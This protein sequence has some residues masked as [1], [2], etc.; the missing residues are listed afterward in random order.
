MDSYTKTPIW[1]EISA[2][3]RSGKQI[4]HGG[5]EGPLG[6]EGITTYIGENFPVSLTETEVVV[7]VGAR[8]LNINHVTCK[9]GSWGQKILY[10]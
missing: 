4:V 6:K 8:F 10:R 2:T 9:L 1:C 5:S 3:V 7:H